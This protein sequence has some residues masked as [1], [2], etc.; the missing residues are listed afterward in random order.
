MIELEKKKKAKQLTKLEEKQTIACSTKPMVQCRKK[1][2]PGRMDV[3]PTII[4]EREFQLCSLHTCQAHQEEYVD[5][6]RGP[7][8]T[9]RLYNEYNGILVSN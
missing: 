9:S 5:D 1:G 4:E 3:L 6:P 2:E 7:V 8:T